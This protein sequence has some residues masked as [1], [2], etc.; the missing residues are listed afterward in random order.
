MTYSF[1]HFD[2]PSFLFVNTKDVQFEPSFHSH[3]SF[4]IKTPENT[5]RLGE[6]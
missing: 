3:M 6:N 1:L 5:E 2:T 4:I